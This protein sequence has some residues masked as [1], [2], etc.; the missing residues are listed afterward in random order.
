M[1]LTV[2]K[3]SKNKNFLP[4]AQASLVAQILMNLPAM[5]EARVLSLGQKNPLE[6]VK[7]T[8][9]SFLSWRIPC[10]EEFGGQT[11]GRKESETTE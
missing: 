11:L 3:L 1:S 2:Y 8:H 5:W 6:K 4:I 10:T 9:F 7:A